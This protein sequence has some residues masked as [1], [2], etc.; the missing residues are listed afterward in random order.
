MPNLP[1]WI[2]VEAWSLFIMKRTIRT[3]IYPR[4]LKLKIGAYDFYY[5]KPFFYFLYYLVC[6]EIMR[7]SLLNSL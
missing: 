5:I 4:T 6:H 1:S 7:N 3:K 2:Y